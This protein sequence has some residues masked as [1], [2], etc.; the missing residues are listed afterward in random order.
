MSIF[1]LL[2][3]LGI[4]PTLHIYPFIHL[5]TA[6]FND[7]SFSFLYDGPWFGLWRWNNRDKGTWQNQNPLISCLKH[8]IVVLYIQVRLEHHF[9]RKTSPRW[10]GTNTHTHTHT[11]THTYTHT[12]T[13]HSINYGKCYKNSLVYE[14][15]E[16]ILN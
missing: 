3:G 10:K 11:H 7:I 8:T 9:R 6:P 15:C 13:N 2:V 1:S 5:C 16:D 14:I 12:N 4:Y